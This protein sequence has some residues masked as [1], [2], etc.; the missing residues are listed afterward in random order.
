[1]C[2]GPGHAQPAGR[3]AHGEPPHRFDRVLRNL[4]WGSAQA[5]ALTPDPS[6]PCPH[7]LCNSRPLE[8][9]N[10][11]QDVHLEFSGRRRCVDALGKRDERHTK[12]LEVIEQGD[13]VSEA[14]S[15]TIETPADEHVEPAP[16]GVSEQLIK[17]WTLNRTPA[18]ALIDI[19]TGLP[20]SGLDVFP[21]LPKLVLNFLIV[22]AHTDVDRCPV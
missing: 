9:G 3:L 19:L 15:E 20:A 1:M 4:G 17:S 18:D 14:P 13:Q 22:C 11:P 16:L 7:P 6:K 2:R 10:G 8:L 5:S 12:R 21:K